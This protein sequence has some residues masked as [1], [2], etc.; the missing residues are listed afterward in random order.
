M[1]PDWSGRDGSTASSFTRPATETHGPNEGKRLLVVGTGNSGVE[2]CVDLIEGGAKPCGSQF[3]RCH[4]AER[5]RRARATHVPILDV[6]LVKLI[7]EGRVEP[8]VG[9]L[10]VLAERTGRP[11]RMG[12][13]E[14]PDSPGLHFVGY[15]NPISG[16]LWEM[17]WEARR[18]ARAA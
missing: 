18:I 15:R 11:L 10:G 3:A 6:G 12:G 2:L 14:D 9:H 7:K 16:M 1:L 17:S 5:G 8:L 13:E 4:T